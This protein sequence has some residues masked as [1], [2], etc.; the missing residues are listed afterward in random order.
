MTTE[1]DRPGNDEA[2]GPSAGLT[3]TSNWAAPVGR[4]EVGT[5]PTA[6]LNLNVAGRRLAGPVQGFGQ[7]WQKTYRIAL[8]SGDV[9]PEQIIRTWKGHFAEFWPKGNRFYGPLTSLEPGEV[10]VLNLAMPGKMT[11]STG[12]LVIYADDESF[13]FMT[14]EGHQFAAWITFSA[15]LDDPAP[16][17]QV[18][19][20]MRASD[21]LYELSMPI[22]G[23]RMEDRFWVATLQALAARFGD[24][25]ARVDMQRVCVDRRRQWRYARN[26]RQNAA[27]RTTIYRLTHP[28]AWFRHTP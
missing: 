4:L 5:V 9:T 3:R 11:L 19:S 23:H 16:V 27:I 24:A 25:D 18:Q 2:P 22:V 14:P 8:S 6:A 13:A 7:L 20:L 26:I 17:I 15:Y 1:T 12:V 10:A 28:G 21:P